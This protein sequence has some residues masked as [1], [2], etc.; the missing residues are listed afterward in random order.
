MEWFAFI[1]SAFCTYVC[2]SIRFNKNAGNIK[3]AVGFAMDTLLAVLLGI[4][5]S[6]EIGTYTCPAGEFNG[7]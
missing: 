2:L 1:W 5:I 6:M 3:P 7:W 4:G